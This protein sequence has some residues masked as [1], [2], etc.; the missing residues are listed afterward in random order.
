MDAL[1]K[2]VQFG[3]NRENFVAILFRP[4]TLNSLLCILRN[5]WGLM[6]FELEFVPDLLCISTGHSSQV[7]LI[8]IMFFRMSKDSHKSPLRLS[9][10]LLVRWFYWKTPDPTN[11]IFTSAVILLFSSCES[12]CNPCWTTFIVC[13]T[14]QQF[15]KKYVNKLLKRG[16]HHTTT[17]S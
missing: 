11:L 5:A 3:V 7:A 6:S 2:S 14:S 16:H 9:F 13:Y 12:V 15:S 17:K 1:T 4:T 8:F 10:L